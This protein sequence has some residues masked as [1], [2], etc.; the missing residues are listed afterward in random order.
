MNRNTSTNHYLW[1]DLVRNKGNT[2]HLNKSAASVTNASYERYKYECNM[3]HITTNEYYYW[4]RQFSYYIGITFE[5]TNS[6]NYFLVHNTSDMYMIT[7]NQSTIHYKHAY[8]TGFGHG[9]SVSTN[10]IS[11]YLTKYVLGQSY[12]SVTRKQNCSSK[13]NNIILVFSVKGAERHMLKTFAIEDIIELDGPSVYFM[14]M[15]RTFAVDFVPFPQCELVLSYQMV[16]RE[17]SRRNQSA[18][19]EGF[20]RV[21]IKS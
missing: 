16:V 9:I 18:C 8:Y 19:S 10:K 1:I 12:I 15:F 7:T 14:V 20:F 17:I 11:E 5:D 4:T 6:S 3:I 2:I 21:I 13:E